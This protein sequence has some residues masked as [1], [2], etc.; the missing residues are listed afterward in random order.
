MCCPPTRPSRASRRRPPRRRQGLYAR[1]SDRSGGIEQSNDTDRL[2]RRAQGRARRRHRRKRLSSADRGERV[3]GYQAQQRTEFRGGHRPERQRLGVSGTVAVVSLQWL[4]FDFGERAAIVDAAKQASVI[5]NIAFTAAHQQLIYDVSLAFYA[6]AAA[7]ARLATATQ[8]LRNA[9]AVQAAAEDRHK[10]GIGTVIEVAQASQGTAQ[11]KLAVVQATG[12]AQDA[13]LALIAAM[14]VSPLTKIRVADVSGRRLSPS[15]ARPSAKHHRR[16]DRPT[17]R[18]AGRLCRSEGEPR[19][20]AG[21]AGRIP[22]QS[23]SSSGDRRLQQRRLERQ[24]DPVD[25]ASSRRRSTSAAAMSAAPYSPASAVPIYDGGTRAA[26]LEQ[27]HAEA[28]SADA[29]LTRM[30]DEAVRLIVLADNA[31]RTSLAALSASRALVSAAQTTFDAALAAYRNGV[32]SITDAT[33]G[34][35][36]A[37]AGKERVHRR[38]QHRAVGRGDAGA[39]DRDARRRAAIVARENQRF[40]LPSSHLR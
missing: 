35:D 31:L 36:P 25:W 39:F 30:R 18:R 37:S 19:Q 22:A 16:S 27:A 9:E 32:G 13:Y 11:A 23:S 17:A 33:L 3:R 29:R 14:G 15:M 21:G 1:G 2:E 24:R 38:L 40:G 12:G 6:H 8:S 28:D 7:R 26:I 10:H 5:S 4:L 20:R 34:G